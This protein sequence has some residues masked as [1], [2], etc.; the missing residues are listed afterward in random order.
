MNPQPAQPQP[1]PLSLDPATLA[2]LLQTTLDTLPQHPA[3]TPAE[4]T[5]SRQAA[6]VVIA[7]LRPRDATEALL[8]A[9]TVATHHAAMDCLRCASQPGLPLALKLRC[10]GKFATLSRLA[11]ATRQALAQAQARPALQPATVPAPIPAPRPQPAP[12]AAPPATAAPPPQRA[13]IKP[14][15]SLPVPSGA[16]PHPAIAATVPPD[17]AIGQRILREIAARMLTAPIA[18]AA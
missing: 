5:A 1:T 10:L 2:A 13:A 17:D 3:A 12:P 8:A 7:T 11:D 14:A 4:I 18:C 6:V 15:P 16:P 9:R